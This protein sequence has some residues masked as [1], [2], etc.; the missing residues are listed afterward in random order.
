ME[1]I[2]NGILFGDFKDY[3][4]LDSIALCN[5]DGDT[6]KLRIRHDDYRTPYADATAVLEM[7]QCVADVLNDTDKNADVKFWVIDD[8]SKN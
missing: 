2:K 5:N 3:S 7:L 4:Y 8:F 6:L 1:K